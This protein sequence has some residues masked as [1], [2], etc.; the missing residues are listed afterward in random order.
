MCVFV[1]AFVSESVCQRPQVTAKLLKYANQQIALKVKNS[2]LIPCGIDLFYTQSRGGT[3]NWIRAEMNINGIHA[4]LICNKFKIKEIK[5]ILC[6]GSSDW[7]I[8]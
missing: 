8:S 7:S 5:F 1:C 2:R 6:K 3:M 4:A